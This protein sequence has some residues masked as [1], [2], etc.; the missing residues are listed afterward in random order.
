MAES[1]WTDWGLNAALAVGLLVVIA[2]GWGLVSRV[3]MPRTVPTRSGTEMSRVQVEVL[4]AAGVDGLA[5]RTREYLIQRGFD[6]VETGNA[7]PRDTTTVLVRSGTALD[8]RHVAQALGL[9][10]GRMVTGGPTTD[11]SLDVT[12]SVGA[13]YRQLTPF[14]DEP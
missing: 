1:R 3:V 10:D 13:D 8:A 9:G 11:Y 4:N 6:V 14:D 7:A 12:L 2:L 5:R